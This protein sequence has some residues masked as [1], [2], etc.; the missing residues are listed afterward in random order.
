[1]IHTHK[2]SCARAHTSA[3]THT[4]CI[5]KRMYASDLVS[6]RVCICICVCVTVYTNVCLCMY[7]CI[8]INVCIC[9]CVCVTAYL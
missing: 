6:E 1:M 8:C 2:R 3:R 5:C 7:N 4:L 9:M